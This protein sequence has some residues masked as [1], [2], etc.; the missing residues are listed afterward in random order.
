MR[1]VVAAAGMRGQPMT[2]VGIEIFEVE[3]P[4]EEGEVRGWV[5]E[6]E[7]REVIERNVKGERSG[8][9]EKEG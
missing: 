1:D 9:R 7:V 3:G 6:W 4:D 8:D 5:R 2:A